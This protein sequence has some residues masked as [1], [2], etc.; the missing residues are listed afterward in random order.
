[1]HFEWPVDYQSIKDVIYSQWMIEGE[2]EML[3]EFTSG[4]TDARVYA[5]DINERNYKGQAILKLDEV[6]RWSDEYKIEAERHAIAESLATDFASSHLPTLI[7]SFENSEKSAMLY[8]LAGD[9][10][11]YTQPLLKLGIDQQIAA[12]QIVAEGVLNDWNISYGISQETI[13]PFNALASWLD[14]RI[15]PKSGGRVHS[16]IEDSCN[17]PSDQPAFTFG[18]YWLPNPLYYVSTQ[19]HW[20]QDHK[21]KLVLGNVHGDLHGNNIFVKIRTPNELEYFLIDLA[22]FSPNT[23]LFYDHAY[24]E[25]SNLLSSRPRCHISRWLKIIQSSNSFESGQ[26][27]GIDVD[28]DDYGLL[29]VVSTI[30]GAIEKWIDRVEAGRKD[31]LEGQAI[32]ARVAA[33]LNFVNKENLDHHQRIL[34]LIYAAESLKL[35][36]DTFKLTWLQQGPIID[37][38]SMALPPASSEWRE[39]WDA[40]NGFDRHQQSFIL[41]SG[42]DV[43]GNDQ[44]NLQILGRIP[45]AVVLDFDS[46]SK[47]GGLYEAVQPTL[48]THRACP[49]IT[50]DTIREINFQE[51]TCWF[52]ANG[53]SGRPETIPNTYDEWRRRYLKYIHSIAEELKRAVSPQPVS[54]IILPSGLTEEQIRAIRERLDEV[55]EDE[56][57]FIILD[58]DVHSSIAL[59]NTTVVSCSL[60]ELTLGLWQMYG[61]APADTQIRV[62][63]RGQD[64]DSRVTVHLN[65]DDYQY[66]KEDL[67]IVHDGLVSLPQLDQRIGDDF[68][69]GH[70][71]TWTELDMSADVTRDILDHLKTEIRSKLDEHRNFSIPLNHKPGA[72]GT[73]LAKRV[74]WDIRNVY[75]TV[76]IHHYSEN[77]ASRIERLF[78]LAKL[79]VLVIM[80]API[81]QGPMREKLYRELRS[82]NTRAVFLYVSRKISPQGPFTLQD[83]MIQREAIRF[84][85]RYKT[86]AKP[87]R[88]P[89]L[90]K[91]TKEEEYVSY[92]SPFFFG[93]YAFE[94]KFVHVPEYVKAHLKYLTPENKQVFS[95]LAL[96]TRFS[97]RYLRDVEI[98]ALLN[99]DTRR[100]LRIQEVFGLGVSRLINQRLGNCRINH[101]LIAEEVLRQLLGEGDTGEAWK[102]KLTDL[103]ISFIEALAGLT[104][105]D[106]IP[107]VDL[108]SEI[109]ISR[110]PWQDVAGL[111][112]NFSELILMINS[113]EGQHRVLTALKDCY[114]NIA[115]FWNHL[116]RHHV[117]V[118]NSRYQAAE[119]CLLKAIVLEPHNDVHHHSLG[120]IYRIGIKRWL[121]KMIRRGV[122]ANQAINKAR[123]LI[124]Q[125]EK[126]FEDARK[127]GPE[128][129]HGYITHIQLLAD[130]IHRLFRLSKATDYAEFLSGN[131]AAAN[132]ARE[133]LP[134]AS[135]LLRRVK[136]FQAQDSLSQHTVR[137]EATLQNFYG[138][139]DNMVKS[140]Q[141]LLDRAD[142]AHVP[143]RRI[144]ANA[145]YAHRGYN[146]GNLKP[147]DLRKIHSLMTEN[148][149]HDSTNPN[150]LLMWF[151]SYRRLA[152]FDMLEAIDRFN[153]W[154]IREDTIE[155]NYY[156]FILHFLR[157]RQGILDD[158]RLV[159]KYRDICASKAGKLGRVYSN[160][161]LAKNPS[162]CP[163]AHESEL[164][165]WDKDIN[166]YKHPH[167]L[168]RLSGIIKHIKGPQAGTIA[169]DRLE[170][171]FVPGNEFLP[172]KDEGTDVTFYLG[173]SYE[174]LRGWSPER[175]KKTLT[176]ST[177]EAQL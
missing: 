72:G 113:K 45:W 169:L 80:E 146:W 144:L 166:F 129:E 35:Y 174:G 123:E 89:L 64:K 148:L 117:Y 175:K 114:P 84:Y 105:V 19:E 108:L 32:L 2:I 107:T 86:I 164:G 21:I 99:L 39:V 46:N 170:V 125:A 127:L 83:P 33:G 8:S 112:R 131:G 139:F 167:R 74:A 42:P 177:T 26:Q 52:M 133:K 56:A 85:D 157:W 100:P 104:N 34:S 159:E 137:C 78:H 160:E 22:L 11:N 116:G 134:V 81:V 152:N 3:R 50:Y 96:V 102:S 97:Q 44:I 101:P 69:H 15:V 149:N 9:T 59:S 176:S 156:L 30:R 36:L 150:D 66:M 4:K 20:T 29:K 25:L 70:E 154:A 98:L 103:S 109:Y 119:T 130:V 13:S 93:L 158:H 37:F 92:R 168:E 106:S 6:K 58:K 54:I 132:W 128:N 90:Y 136:I 124:E 153:R 115:H 10:L 76:R 60:Q 151:Q 171:F 172:G 5:V 18:G 91:L 38:G 75:P 77:T 120:M 49:L 53:I 121:D 55:L 142:I 165:E 27:G 95:Y 47:S 143:V 51:S 48:Q 61:D 17:I 79:P 126:C 82:R 40:C 73:T 24:L 63:G 31:H 28:P 145:Y 57:S 94:D 88:I 12:T 147:L 87:S 14:Y 141:S 62:P 16:F 110:D 162:W 65:N 68:W 41:I 135:E 155:A 7:D 111:R 173:F 163:L 161:W 43:R 23:Y 122:T 118:L 140:L 71:I 1:M 67:E 138:R